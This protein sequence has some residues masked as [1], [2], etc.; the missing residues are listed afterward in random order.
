ML[1]LV[2]FDLDG[3]LT[4]TMNLGVEAVRQALLPYTG[5]PLTYEEIGTAFGLS[6]PGM[7]EKLAPGHGA[8]AL[9][10]FF[11]AYEA[12][13][14][15]VEAPFDGVIDLLEDL[16]KRGLILILITGKCR[17]TMEIT[18][19][20][21]GLAPYFDRMYHGHPTLPIKADCMREALARYNVKPE[22]AFYVGDALRDITDSQ[23]VGIPCLSAAWERAVDP[24]AQ[25]ALKPHKQFFT[26]AE[27]RAYLAQQA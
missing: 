7:L 22:E 18:T 11:A 6:E 12:L 25:R 4:D 9:E 20:R 2:G 8:E 15:M 16:K 19:R 14:P 17:Q 21:L 10:P 13:H 1:K 26:I 24:A 27:L 5:R 23:A 3:T